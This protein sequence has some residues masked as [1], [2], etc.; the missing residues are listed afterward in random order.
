M[1]KTRRIFLLFLLLWLFTLD[2]LVLTKTTLNSSIL[3]KLSEPFFLL[4][5][6]NITGTNLQNNPIFILI[7]TN[8]IIAGL[9]SLSYFTWE[10]NRKKE[11][12]K[13]Q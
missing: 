7:L 5:T 6:G 12:K 1:E 4:L 2:Y 3:N 13:K 8:V 9:F 11:T 10:K